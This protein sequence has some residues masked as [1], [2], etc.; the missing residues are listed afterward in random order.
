MTAPQSG[1]DDLGLEYYDDL[2]KQPEPQQKD[3]SFLE[4][5]APFVAGPILGTKEGRRH[6]A[7]TVS[8]VGETLM[9]LPGDIR[10]LFNS[11]AVGIP[12][13]FAGEELPNWRNI[14]EGDPDIAGGFFSGPTSSEIREGISKS[15]GDDY[16]EPQSKWEEFGDNVAQDFASL[17]L[18][19]KGKIPFARSLGTSILANSGGE[20]AGA[21]GG[22]KAEA[23]TKMG[24]L[25]SGGMIGHGQ[26]GVK[27]HIRGLYKDMESSLPKG[28][29]VSSKGLAPKLDKIESVLKKGDPLDASKQPA[30]QKIQAIRDKISGNDRIGV[31]E[32]IELNKST[33]EAIFGLGDLKRGQHKLYD[34]RNA[35]HESIGEY[36]KQNADFLGK[37]KNANEAYAATETSRKVSNWVRKNI[38][39]KDYIYAAGA[40]GLEGGLM[41]ASTALGTAGGAAALGATAY[42]AEVLKRISKSP[43]LRKYYQNVVTHSLNQNKA[44]FIRAVKQ[45]DKGLKSDF[46]SDPYETVDFD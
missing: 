45:L 21:F 15:V 14:V 36:G 27:Q 16:L 1:N 39:P 31:D 24:L 5:A 12:E 29:E 13:Y 8:R 10:E 43:A 26:G 22:E 25:F 20:I 4:K 28:A 34:I 44:G 30:F 18:P 41:G 19:V 23:A 7:R 9:G 32:L 17:A 40:L 6:A 11:I 33:N 2:S 42:S 35:L 46:K 3:K 38:K 37:W